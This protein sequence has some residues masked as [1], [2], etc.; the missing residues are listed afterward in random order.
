MTAASIS[1]FTVFIK[2]FK[3]IKAYARLSFKKMIEYK[4]IV[5]TNTLGYLFV[6]VAWIFFW[7]LLFGNIKEIGEWK[8]P[9]LLL[10]VGF[11][12]LS[13]ALW[14][15]FWYTISFS[16]DIMKGNL[17]VYLVRPIHPLYGL[18]MREMQLFSLIPAGFGLV[19]ILYA[20]FKY[21]SVTVINLAIALFMCVIAAA[22]L[23]VLYST[24]MSLSFWLGKI[25]AVRTVFRSFHIIQKYPLDIFSIAVRNFFTFVVPLYFFGTAQVVAILGSKQVALQYLMLEIAIFLFWLCVWQFTWTRGVRRYESY[26]G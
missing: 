3:L 26:G 20:S 5:V 13:D 23:G 25:S 10:L 21:Y 16:S 14:Q 8:Y 17:D 1:V 9:M 15:I 7:N 24:I 18:V 4:F 22:M 12:Y 2:H 19:L 11:L 6:M